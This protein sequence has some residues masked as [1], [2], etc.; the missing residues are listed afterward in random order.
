MK[1][2]LSVAALLLLALAQSG[3]SHNIV[4]S[5]E[6]KA[7][8]TFKLQVAAD[9]KAHQNTENVWYSGAFS[10]ASWYRGKVQLS[11]DFTYNVSK[12]D[13]LVSPYMGIAEVAATGHKSN[14][15]YTKEEALT[16][17]LF[18]AEYSV[19]HRL[20]YAFQDHEWVVKAE[21]CNNAKG[22]YGW[23]V[24]RSEGENAALIEK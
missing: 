16:S 20:T 11:D 12:T 10:D 18:P 15:H 19:R 6:E 5:D 23:E 21:E 3:C 24:C 4:K 13:S 7:L 9:I 1:T 14:A 22:G 17:D 2:I 8:D